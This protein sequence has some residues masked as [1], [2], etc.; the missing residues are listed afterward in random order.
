MAVSCGIGNVAKETDLADRNV[1]KNLIR[2]LQNAWA[3]RILPE[4]NTR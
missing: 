4:D 2:A 1:D 3:P